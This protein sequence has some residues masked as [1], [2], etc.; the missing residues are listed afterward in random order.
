MVVLSNVCN[1]ALVLTGLGLMVWL[2][3]FLSTPRK[4]KQFL[5]TTSAQYA[6]DAGGTRTLRMGA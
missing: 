3:V 1:L 2:A 6:A 4:R 5:A